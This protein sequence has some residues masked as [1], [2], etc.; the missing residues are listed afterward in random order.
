MKVLFVDQFGK[1]TGRDTLALAELININKDVEME[2][3]LSDNTE[4]PADRSYSI[5]IAKGF[6]GAYEGSFVNKALNYLK[7]LR[8]LKEYIEKTH[9]D[10][11]HLQWFSLPWLEWIHLG[12]LTK[13]QKVVI[14]VH[15]VIPFDNRPMEMKC[16]DKIY[17]KANALVMHTETS[18]N[19]F[20]STYKAKTPISVVTQG[21]CL[22]SDYSIINKSE[23]KK[24]F[25]IPEDS[26]VFL[27]YGT[28]RPSKGLNILI[29]SIQKAHQKNKKVYL[30]AAGAFHKVNEDEYKTL[31]KNQLDNSFSNVRFGFVPQEEEKW[32]FSAAD[33]VCLPYLE[34]TQSGVAQLGLMYELPIIATNIGEMFDVCRDNKNGLLVSAGDEN[35]LTDA[36]IKMTSDDVFRKAAS[37]ESKILGET[38]FSLQIKANKIADTYRN[39]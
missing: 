26:I 24:H 29:K 23:A 3:Y 36:I 28:I 4:I 19:L 5:K 13:K 30:L 7:A 27:N 2:V 21:F 31:V 1:T 35:S 14:T 38:E 18:K 16:L 33:V 22:K 37:Y 32:Y 9:P 25:C 34:V 15:D 20:R 39:L 12:G 6:H 10:I 8:A 11:V 17:S